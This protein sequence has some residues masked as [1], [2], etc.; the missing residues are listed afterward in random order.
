MDLNERHKQMIESKLQAESYPAQ[1]WLLDEDGQTVADLGRFRVVEEDD[2]HGFY[3]GDEGTIH[4][5]VV[6][7]EK[8]R[9]ERVAYLLLIDGYDSAVDVPD[10]SMVDPI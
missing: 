2:D 10:I 7:S 3:A 8:Y 4:A 1:N 9:N 5:S 6:G